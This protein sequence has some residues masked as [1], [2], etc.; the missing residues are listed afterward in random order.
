MDHE[1]FSSTWPGVIEGVALIGSMQIKG[2]ASVGG[3]L[4]N[5]SPAADSVPAII[6]ADAICNVMGP[7]G[8]RQVDAGD[9]VVAPGNNSLADRDF[10]VKYKLA[11]RQY[12]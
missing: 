1:G 4:C 7:G 6:A 9:I 5:A 2:R 12:H 11:K 8:L 3:N 10:I